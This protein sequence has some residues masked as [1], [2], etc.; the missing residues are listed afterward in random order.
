MNIN[1]PK[2]IVKR[3]TLEDNINIVTNFISPSFNRGNKTLPFA[4]YSYEIFPELVGLIKDDM[5]NKQVKEIITPVVK[6]KIKQYENEMKD[7]IIRLQKIFDKINDELL[8]SL[9]DV[10]EINW[11]DNCKEIRCYIGY[12]P[13]C[14]RDIISKKFWVSYMMSDE[15]IIKTAIHEMAHFIFYEKWEDIYGEVSLKD[16]SIPSPSW[17]LSEM[18]VDPLLNDGRIQK[19]VSLKHKAYPKFYTETINGVSI[20]DNLKKYYKDSK[21][22]EE[23]IKKSYDFVKDNLNE[24]N[25]KCN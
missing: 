21:N 16:F 1:V 5:T 22:V 9:A 19:V 7:T 2:I 11:P 18:I 24:I 3:I 23:F 20:I 14:P 10:H 15:E 12:I 13:V 25:K 4:K 8:V 17:Y 6:N